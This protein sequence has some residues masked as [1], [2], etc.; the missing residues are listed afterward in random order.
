MVG[1]I[2]TME[3][4]GNPENGWRGRGVV[5]YGW[6]NAGRGELQSEVR[7]GGASLSFS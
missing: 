4:N 7:L 1:M 6:I 5:F 2:K 3:Y